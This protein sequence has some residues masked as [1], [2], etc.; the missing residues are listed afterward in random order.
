MRNKIKRNVVISHVL[1][2]NCN[3]NK[4]LDKSNLLKNLKL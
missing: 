4:I 2:S 3:V 1:V